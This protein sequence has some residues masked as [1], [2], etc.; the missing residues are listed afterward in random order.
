MP[1]L[2][3]IR[4]WQLLQ[5]RSVSLKSA[6]NTSLKPRSLPWSTKWSLR[7]KRQKRR[8]KK[9]RTR[10]LCSTSSR[11]RLSRQM[12][13][14]KLLS[15]SKNRQRCWC[16]CLDRKQTQKCAQT[17]S[18]KPNTKWSQVFLKSRCTPFTRLL[19]SLNF[20]KLSLETMLTWSGLSSTL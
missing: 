17:T 13:S 12:I 2:S 15:M 3:L 20:P 6:S 11:L 8:S 4:K 1:W 7:T 10:F 14:K 19:S 9:L 18:C 16:S 5:S